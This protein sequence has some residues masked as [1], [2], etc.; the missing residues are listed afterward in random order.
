MNDLDVGTLTDILLYHVTSGRFNSTIVPAG[1]SFRM[2]N[3]DTLTRS[4]LEAAGIAATDI[5]ASNGIVHVINA[6]LLP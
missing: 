1:P 4:D 5:S 3:G 6:V 2:L